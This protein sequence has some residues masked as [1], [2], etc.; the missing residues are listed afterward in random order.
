MAAIVHDQIGSGECAA[1][2]A[3][4]DGEV[5]LAAA[6]TPLNVAHLCH[7]VRL[8]VR[9][10]SES[11]VQVYRAG[12][13]RS[14]VELIDGGTRVPRAS[15]AA[16]QAQFVGDDM[17]A[18][19]LLQSD[20]AEVVALHVYVVIREQPAVQCELGTQPEK[21]GLEQQSGG[22]VCPHRPGNR[23]RRRCYPPEVHSIRKSEVPP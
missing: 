14:A 10:I 17:R 8:T 9:S 18:A 21:I 23:M 12:R 19:I 22:A 4:A 1:E 2:Q 20:T 3:D 5:V 16:G 13:E 6:A 11:G 7:S 15:C